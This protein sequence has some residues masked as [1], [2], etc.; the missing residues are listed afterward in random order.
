V[1]DLKSNTTTRKWDNKKKVWSV[2]VSEKEKTLEILG[3]YFKVAE[4]TSPAIEDS[5]T[6][7]MQPA[8]NDGKFTVQENDNVEIWTDGACSGNPGAGGYAA[9]LKNNGRIKEVTGGFAH[10][11]NNRMEIAAA[12]TALESLDKPC[13]TTI[14]SDS[15]YL[16]DAVTLGWAKKWQAN[17]WMRN[18]KDK[19]INPDLWQKLLEQTAK[20]RVKFVWVKGHSTNRQNARCDELAEAITH[21]PGMPA[22]K[23]YKK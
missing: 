20:H 8:Q 17:G 18:K 16:V 9:L 4:D 5:D 2:N 12:I 15:K 11:T 6:E 10:T 3:K 22:D 14:F 21:L 7:P 19:A 23:G 13:N 1:E